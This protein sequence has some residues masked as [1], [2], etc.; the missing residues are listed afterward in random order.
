MADATDMTSGTLA[1][2]VPYVSFGSG[3]P[4]VVLTGLTPDHTNPTG[5]RLKQEL[6]PWEPLR[7][8]RTVHVVNRRPGVAPDCT[9]ADVA[10]DCARAI[11][12]RFGGPVDVVGTSTGGSVALQLAIDHP[13]LVR[14]LVLASAACRLAL[15][16]REAQ[17]Q[18]A[19]WTVAGQPR[20]AWAS[21]GP[22]IAPGPITS[23]LMTALLWLFAKR[24]APDDPSDMLATIQA[25]ERFDV[26]DDLGRVAAPTLVL[27]GARDPFYS[28]ELFEATAR[29]VPGG[30]LHLFADKGHGVL[31]DEE[32]VAEIAAFIAT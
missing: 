14:R 22:M 13:Q 17:R 5:M 21:L 16:G 3:P 12:D 9:M 8:L 10:A 32:V 28:A 4:L 7:E 27:G 19:A 18:L 20:R 2:D 6:A 15:G 24:V 29:G 23:R 25:E 11:K 30:R 26:C 31:K 1:G